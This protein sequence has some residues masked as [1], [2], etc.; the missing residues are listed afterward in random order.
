MPK[1]SPVPEDVDR[2]FFEAANQD[3]LVIQNCTACNRLQHPPQP[4]CGACGSADHLEWKEMSGKGTIYSYAVVYDSP[5]ASLQA[6]QPYNC[7]IIALDEDPG[8]KMLSHLPGTPVDEVPM[9]APVR[10]IFE[11]TQATG[12]KVVEWQVVN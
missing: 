2:G 10:A 8:I 5:V 3:R 9:D 12:Q 6:D 7:A 1:Q 4:A 11:V